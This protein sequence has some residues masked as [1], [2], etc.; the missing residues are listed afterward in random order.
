MALIVTRHTPSTI[1][2]E[3]PKPFLDP[4]LKLLVALE[5]LSVFGVSE[6][7]AFEFCADVGMGGGGAGEGRVL[8]AEVK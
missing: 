1:T 8:F 7:M 6:L 5:T 3:G 2:S 4:L